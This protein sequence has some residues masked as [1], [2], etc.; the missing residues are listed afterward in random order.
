MAALAIVLVIC[1]VVIVILVTKYN[2]QKALQVKNFTRGLT[3]LQLSI[4]PDIPTVPVRFEEKER[5]RLREKY[6]KRSELTEPTI[7][8]AISSYRDPELCVTLLDLMDKAYNPARVFVG[9]VEQ[10]DPIDKYSSHAKNSKLPENQLRVITMHHKEAKGPTHARAICEGLYRGEDY[11][12][13]IDSHMRFEPGWD[14][15]L[16]NMLFNCRRPRR[17][18]IT[19]YPEGYERKDE[20]GQVTY[21]YAVSAVLNKNWQVPGEE[22]LEVRATQKV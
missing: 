22:G 10:N 2:R 18:A 5:K 17:T 19:M 3:C 12:M 1:I 6:G 16:L 8:V 11:Y 15:E 9:V 4:H 20:G 14:V 21:K 13:M 7:F